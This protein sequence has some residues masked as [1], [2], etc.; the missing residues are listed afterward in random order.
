MYSTSPIGPWRSQSNPDHLSSAAMEK[1]HFRFA[2]SWSAL[3][4]NLEPCKLDSWLDSASPAAEPVVYAQ[5]MALSPPSFVAPPWIQ[6]P[7]AAESESVD[8]WEMV[9]PKMVRPHTKPVAEIRLHPTNRLGHFGLE[10]SSGHAVE[11]AKPLLLARVLS[12]IERRARTL[13]PLTAL[14][15]PVSASIFIPFRQLSPTVR[16]GLVPAVS[17]THLVRLNTPSPI[18]DG[19]LG[20]A[21]E[22]NR[23][24]PTTRESALSKIRNALKSRPGRPDPFPTQ[25]S[26]KKRA[27][28]L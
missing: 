19:N 7:E 4:A 8:R 20:G 27:G 5:S 1:K 11:S 24:Q 2:V 22:P 3:T 6:Q 17:G 13:L 12:A 26:S 25:L 9:V 15:P 28:V 16:A 18:P 23:S 21:L 10:T 14:R